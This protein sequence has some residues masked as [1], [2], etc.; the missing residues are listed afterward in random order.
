[1][2]DAPVTSSL[3]A[4]QTVG[5]GSRLLVDVGPV[6]AWMIVYN[7]VSRTVRDA[8]ELCR[9]AREALETAGTALSPEAV[10][11]CAH[12]E[13]PIYVGVVVFTLATFAALIY[14]RV[15]QKRFPP[16]LAVTAVLVTV[17]AAM[18]LYFQN[19][20]FFYIKPTVVNL[21][22]AAGILGSLLV[23]Q[24]VLKMFV[25][26]A[27]TLPD[28]IWTILAIRWGIWFVFLAILNEVI[29]RNFSEQFWANFK[30]FGVLP[31]TFAFALAN[32]PLTMKHAIVESDGPGDGE[33]ET[34]PAG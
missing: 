17:F 29:W 22:Y 19:P 12:K 16:L 2:S 20:V 15:V 3:T 14:A 27:Y 25:G 9:S 28:R 18:T 8:R 31:L 23:K 21:L 30:F 4:T 32:V 26:Y 24:N 10:E 13:L 11:A 5:Q 1:M 6:I 33:D 34:S 7:L